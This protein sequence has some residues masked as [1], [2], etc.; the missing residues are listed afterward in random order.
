MSI[1]GHCIR[2]VA[3]IIL[4]AILF[5]VCIKSFGDQVAV[6]GVPLLVAALAVAWYVGERRDAP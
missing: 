4:W 5:F 3:W 2:T 1:V 6:V